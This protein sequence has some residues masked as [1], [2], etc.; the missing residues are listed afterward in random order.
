LVFD[1]SNPMKMALQHVQTVPVPPSARTTLP[2]P[3][4]LERIVLACLA[5][6]PADRPPSAATVA[7]MLAACPVDHWTN[8]DTEAWWRRHLPPSSS[9][10]TLAQNPAGMPAIIR[11][12]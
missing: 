7:N 12:V 5:K 4:A 1:D 3:E 6:A 2:I 10:R 11:K 8:E 9:L